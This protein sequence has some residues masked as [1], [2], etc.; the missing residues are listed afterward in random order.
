VDSAVR[1]I[2]LCK[3]KS[4]GH[5]KKKIAVVRPSPFPVGRPPGPRSERFS[6]KDAGAG[7]AGKAEI[8][9]PPG[10]FRKK[11]P[12]RESFLGCAG[13]PQCGNPAGRAACRAHGEQA[14]S[15]PKYQRLVRR[16]RRTGGQ[17][18]SSW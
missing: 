12:K 10:C 2:I 3:R 13:Q 1:D 14:L 16:R 17:R 9:C 6:W 7:S 15:L 18:L 4:G 8:L 5:E 11:H